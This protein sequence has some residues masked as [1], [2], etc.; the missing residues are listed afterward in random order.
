MLDVLAAALDVHLVAVALGALDHV[1]PV[2]LVDAPL[3]APAAVRLGATAAV[4]AEDAQVFLNYIKKG[5]NV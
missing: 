4:A 5:G 1:E 2:V 3:H